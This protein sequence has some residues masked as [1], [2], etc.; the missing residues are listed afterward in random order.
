MIPK[1][2][3]DRMDWMYDWGNKLQQQKTNEEFLTGQ[4]K[5]D[6][7]VRKEFKHVFQ[8]EVTNNKCEDFSLLHE[9]PMF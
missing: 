1:S 3:L 9:D 6:P 5:A 7:H 2:H 8:E 4:K